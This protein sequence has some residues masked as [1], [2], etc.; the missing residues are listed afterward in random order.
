MALVN[1]SEI[2]KFAKDHK[3]AVGAFNSM[4]MESVQAVVSAADQTDSP[5][6]V[7]TYRDHVAFAGADYMQAIAT[8]ASNHAKVKIA[9]GLDHGNSFDLSR[10]CVENGYTGVMIDLASED[11]DKNVR[12]TRRVVELAH[13]RNVSVEAELGTIHTAD[14]T[15]ETIASGYTDPEVAVRFVRDTGIDCLA[16]SIGTAHGIYKYTPKINFELLDQLVR[17][18]PCPIV[19]HGGSNTPDEDILKM[20]KLGIAKLNVGTDFFIAWNTALLNFYQEHG[21]HIEVV[22]AMAAARSAIKKAA[23]EKLKLLNAYRV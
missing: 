22:D 21:T 18:T 13:S 20:V 23:L 3:C 19:V 17:E 12:E 5:L 15:L 6:I 8:I 7:Q 11:Y 10:V 9:M 16:V 4:N 1:Y 14:S 2:L